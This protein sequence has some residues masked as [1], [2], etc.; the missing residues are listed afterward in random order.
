MDTLQ[1]SQRNGQRE[2]GTRGGRL[3]AAGTAGVLTGM[4]AGLVT[5]AVAGLLV[6]LPGLLPRADALPRAEAGII[7]YRTYLDLHLP[8]PGEPG[9]REP[10]AAEDK[11]N[12]TANRIK[13]DAG[14]KGAKKAARKKQA[15]ASGKLTLD[16]RAKLADERNR[17]LQQWDTLSEELRQAMTAFQEHVRA[18]RMKNMTAAEQKAY[19]K[20]LE[21][22]EKEREQVGRMTGEQRRAYFQKKQ[23]ALM[24][25]KVK[26]MSKEERQVWLERE[27]RREARMEAF[28]EQWKNMTPEEQK[29]WRRDHPMPGGI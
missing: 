14:S 27:K 24:K 16:Q 19:R 23:A 9:F 13:S 17:I 20:Q 21:A 7:A 12:N 6:L 11:T 2:P 3:R 26:T 25:Q 8:R 4:A 1:K 15:P 18:E 10:A 22:R 5:G 28:R 29:A